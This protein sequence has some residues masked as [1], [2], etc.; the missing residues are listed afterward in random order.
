MA[1]ALIVDDNSS[2]VEALAE[3]VRVEGFTTTSALTIEQARLE[4][5]K[6]R[7]DVVLLDLN[8]PDGNGLGLVDEIRQ[9]GTSIVLIT[10]QASV[11]TAVEA[12]RRGVTDYLT[13]PL[14]VERLQKLLHDVEQ[15]SRLPDE[16]RSLRSEQQ[17][18]GRFARI[19]GRSEPILRMCDLLSRIAPS[20]ASV[21]IIGQ[22]G[23][24]KEVVARAIHE[25]SRRRHGPFVPVN[26]GAISP[27]L[28]ES[29]LF[30]HERGS[31]T[32]AER[33]HR[34]FFERATHGTLFLDE[35]TEMPIDLQVKLLRVLETDSVAR[36]GGEQGVRVDVRIL[37]A[38]NRVSEEAIEEGKLRRD[39]YY[40][41][42]V[43][44][45]DLPP[46]CD[47]REDVEL[48]AQTFL[49]D[50]IAAEGRE[51]RFSDEAMRAL[52]AYAWPG[53][54]RE[55]R[56]VVHFAYV[57]SE[58]IIDVDSL[59]QEVL[60]LDHLGER[61][62]GECGDTDSG[63]SFTVRV[64]S[65]IA[66]VERRLIMA[67]L[68]E[69]SEYKPKTADVLGISLKTLYNRLNQYQRIPAGV[70]SA[71]SCAQDAVPSPEDP[72]LEEGRECPSDIEQ[73]PDQL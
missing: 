31:F 35:I 7:P 21:L 30:G 28:M 11:D 60:R 64:G 9:P 42:K 54:V 22:S 19:V 55:L 44:Q 73:S 48:L 62:T 51:K 72:S 20:S 27:S 38:S 69:Y 2:T 61:A 50:L 10:G 66:D 32:G 26:C 53:N 23:T 41:L 65:T 47:R 63:A 13:K 70:S 3:L 4:L 57:L 5:A 25:L 49:D 45:I 29:E 8:L 36:V 67:T 40:R 14:D 16:L 39:L 71:D 24:G 15:T 33:R 46:L 1:H 6:E 37:A 18:T 68:R 17:R 58:D 34:G 52:T 12:L 59:P 56:N 43:F